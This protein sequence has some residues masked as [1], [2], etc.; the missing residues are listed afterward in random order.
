MS[1][2]EWI[3]IDL[4]H[5]EKVKIIG[6]NGPIKIVIGGPRPEDGLYWWHVKVEEKGYA[7]SI[8][9]A[10]KMALDSVKYELENAQ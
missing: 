2:L 10:R 9:E 1:K 5:A 6:D 8:E 4:K 3:T 7:D